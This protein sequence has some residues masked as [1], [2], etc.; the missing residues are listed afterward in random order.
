MHV[1]FNDVAFSPDG[2]R[3]ASG[4]SDGTVALWDLATGLQTLTLKGHVG[5]VRSVAF[6]R[7]GQRLASAGNDGKVRIWDAPKDERK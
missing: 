3:L 6:S 5:K 2:S 1:Y 4:H 7:D